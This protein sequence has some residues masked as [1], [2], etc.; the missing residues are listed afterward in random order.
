MKTA[1]ADGEFVVQHLVK[2][3]ENYSVNPERIQPNGVDIGFES[4]HRIAGRARFRPD[5]YS[6]PNRTEAMIHNNGYY[7][8]PPGAY[9]VVY[10]FEVSVPDGYVGRVYPKSRF[11]R[12]GIHLTSA[13]WD[14]GYVG[15]GEGLLK[16]QRGIETTEIHPDCTV[17][18]MTFI[19]AAQP[20]ESYDGTHQGE[21]LATDD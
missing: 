12:S 18:Q 3:G 20:A 4:I 1:Y 17:G 9:A 19:E 21:R 7:K 10:D 8:L 16:I 6:K 15:K 13:L 5:G 14:Q 2:D 11:M